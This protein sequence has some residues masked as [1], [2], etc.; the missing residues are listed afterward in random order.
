[1]AYTQS[2]LPGVNIVSVGTLNLQQI[3]EA[4]LLCGTLF[5]FDAAVNSKAC[6]QDADCLA[7]GFPFSWLHGEKE[8]GHISGHVSRM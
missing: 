5:G 8:L 6:T 4:Q 2:P 3:Y 7:L 1:M